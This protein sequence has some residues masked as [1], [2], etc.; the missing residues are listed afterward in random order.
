M[1]FCINFKYT[2]LEIPGI[3]TFLFFILFTVSCISSPQPS[4]PETGKPVFGVWPTELAQR[5]LGDH[6]GRLFTRAQATHQRIWSLKQSFS[7]LYNAFKRAILIWPLEVPFW[8][9]PWLGRKD[10]SKTSWVLPA[11]CFQTALCKMQYLEIGTWTVFPNQYS[12]LVWSARRQ[13]SLGPQ[14]GSPWCAVAH[15]VEGP[16]RGP[17]ATRADVGT[18]GNPSP[19]SVSLPSWWWQLFTGTHVPATAIRCPCQKPKAMGLLNPELETNEPF[20][21]WVHS[22]RCRAA[23]TP[24]WLIP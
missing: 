23:V 19:P 12:S 13:C 11:R 17:V 18:M 1:V 20:L 6:W 16:V 21:F 3:Q 7:P 15:Q 22:L 14:S 24:S 10:R 8:Y 4:C 2:M 9:P 5:Y